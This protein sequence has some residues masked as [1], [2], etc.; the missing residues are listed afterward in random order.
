MSEPQG[1]VD[2]LMSRIDGT[3]R[4]RR[5]MR[6]TPK[7]MRRHFPPR[8]CRWLGAPIHVTIVTTAF[9]TAEISSPELSF[10]PD[11][12]AAFH[13]TVDIIEPPTDVVDRHPGAP[14]DQDQ[15]DG[16]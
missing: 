11:G 3:E 13:E 9:D 5:V 6:A 12:T 15:E 7:R 16:Q 4:L 10:L 2:I 8:F 1:E 14:Y